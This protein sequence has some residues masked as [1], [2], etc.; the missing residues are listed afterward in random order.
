MPIAI[1]DGQFGSNATM[2]ARLPNEESSIEW[3]DH[4]DP[5]TRPTMVSTD[6]GGGTELNLAARSDSGTCFY[7]RVVVDAPS[8]HHMD[9]SAG[10]CEAHDYQG[11][12]DGGW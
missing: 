6:E 1:E 4:T 5:S 11:G 10:S 8:T 3:V 2:L 9:P 7:L 12:P